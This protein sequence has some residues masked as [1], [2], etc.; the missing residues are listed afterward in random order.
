MIISSFFFVI[1]LVAFF[2]AKQTWAW[3]IFFIYVFE[4]VSV[5]SFIYLQTNAAIVIQIFGIFLGVGLYSLMLR[6]FT[7]KKTIVIE[8]HKEE[9]H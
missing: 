4:S 2:R 5:L 6:G 7:V 8:H 3:Y 1:A 9:T